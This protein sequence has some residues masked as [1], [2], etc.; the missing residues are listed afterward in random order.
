VLPCIPKGVQVEPQLPG[1][2]GKLKYSNHDVSDDTKYPELASIF[3]MQNI[4]VNQL[5]ET[6]IQPHQWAVGLDQIDIL[7]LLQLPHFGIGQ[8]ATTYIK[9]MLVVMHGG[10]IWM[11]IPVPIKLTLLRR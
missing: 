3:F 5:G 1:H 11:D 7:G 9:N 10:D 2:V 6:I 4:V 8:Y